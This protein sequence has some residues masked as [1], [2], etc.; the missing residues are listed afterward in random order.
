LKIITRA[1]KYAFLI[2]LTSSSFYT[3]LS[4]SAVF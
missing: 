3:H 1:A 4:T 2:A